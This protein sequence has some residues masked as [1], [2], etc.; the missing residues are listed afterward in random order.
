M[1]MDPLARTVPAFLVAAMLALSAG[2]TAAQS[3]AGTDATER[4]SAWAGFSGY[5]G[6]GVEFAPVFEGSQRMS[7]QFAPMADATWKDRVFL[8]DDN[9]LGVWAFKAGGF[10]IGPSIYYSEGR[11]NNGRAH[12]L[13]RID[14]AP[15]FK[16]AAAYRTDLG[17]FT[18]DAGRTAGGDN[19]VVVNFDY[20]VRFTL[21]RS[22]T[23]EGGVGVTWAN[24]RYMRA[25]FGINE[26]QSI[27]T[28]QPV[29][30]VRAGMK[31]V[32]GGISLHYRA[33]EHG[34]IQ[35]SFGLSRL[36][37]DAAFSPITHRDLQPV[38]A[39]GVGYQF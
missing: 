19:G 33:L 4:T 27:A 39:L 22:L 35:L 3:Q 24:G 18:I 37:G 20:G 15:V 26:N 11:N 23:I 34:F 8:N 10:R 32:H 7:L 17:E 12:G 31:D 9:G 5:V 38:V 30:T 25:Y 29:T 1:S 36:L 2:P 16:I 28:G 21:T 14:L 13:G 6:A